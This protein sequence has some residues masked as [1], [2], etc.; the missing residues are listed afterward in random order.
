MGVR[1]AAAIRDWE[2]GASP[3]RKRVAGMLAVR[4]AWP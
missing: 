4:T 3:W 1:C 2:S